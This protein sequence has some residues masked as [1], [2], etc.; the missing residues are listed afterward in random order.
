MERWMQFRY[1]N[2]SPSMVENVHRF[3]STGGKAP[4]ETR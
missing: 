3:A 4:G 1:R 2:E